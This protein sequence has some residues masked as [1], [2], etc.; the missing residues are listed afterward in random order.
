MSYKHLTINR[1][2]ILTATLFGCF[3]LCFVPP[4][5]SPDEFNHFYRAWQIS[6]GALTGEK[7]NDNRLGDSLPV[8][9]LVISKPFQSLPFQPSHKIKRDTILQYLKTPAEHEQKIFI[10]FTNTAL[11]APTAYLPQ[12]LAIYI[13]N[14][15]SLYPPITNHPL[16]IFYIARLFTLVF[17]MLF[18]ELSLRIIPFRKTL[19]A[20]LA[21]LPSS[22]FINSSINADVVT[23]AFSFLLIALACQFIFT[24]K[25]MRM[26]HALLCLSLSCLITL[27]KIAYTP[28][29]LLFLL[30]KTENFGY[31]HRKIAFLILLAAANIGIAYWWAKTIEPLYITYESYHPHYRIGQQ[32][33]EGVNP[34]SQMQFIL[35]NPLTYSKILVGSLVET[36]PHTLIHYL[37]KFG[38]EKNYLPLWLL[39]PLFLLLILRGGAQT[40]TSKISNFRAL[41]FLTG[42]LMTLSLATAMYLIWCP[43][44]SSRIENLSG[45]YFIPIFPIFF[46]ALPSIVL[47]SLVKS[48]MMWIKKLAHTISPIWLWLCLTY[49]VW[50]VID[51]YYV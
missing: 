5:Q 25:K 44:G 7:T 37:G 45:K 9:L 1:Y 40:N 26:G 27:N 13:F 16:S 8:S 11:Y 41:A 46:L 43:V 33:N 21:L 35:H 2:F 17:W 12:A 28:I 38:W 39:I 47:F 34:K 49:A 31:R 19:F 14:R 50:Q 42:V 23:N 15:P 3:Y 20:Y 24:K 10:D 22:L 32:L 18:I 48:K 36:L 4:F 6:E 29:L 51:R 30:A